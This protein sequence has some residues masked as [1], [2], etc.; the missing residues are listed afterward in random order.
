MPLQL[1]SHL[2]PK[3]KRP[4]IVMLTEMELDLG[5]SQTTTLLH[6]LVEYQLYPVKKKNKSQQFQ[7]MTRF[8]Q[9]VQ[10]E[11][12]ITLWRPN[13]TYVNEGK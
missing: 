7:W 1:V 2:L 13:R 6:K 5:N 10:I 3:G 8:A 9:I 4:I 11:R 12:N